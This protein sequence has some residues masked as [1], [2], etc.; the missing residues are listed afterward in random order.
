MNLDSAFLAINIIDRVLGLVEC[1][2]ELFSVLTATSLFMAIKY[3]ET[4]VL[5]LHYYLSVVKNPKLTAE[6]VRE[7]EAY[8]LG[9]LDFD[10]SYVSPIKF[11]DC[12]SLKFKLST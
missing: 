9:I 2:E 4:L 8:I 3:N 7:T 5:K 1:T 6:E 12:L 10:L 11:I